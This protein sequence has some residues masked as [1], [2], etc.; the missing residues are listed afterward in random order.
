MHT[1]C[2]FKETEAKPLKPWDSTSSLEAFVGA[3]T[4]VWTHL[5]STSRKDIYAAIAGFYEGEELMARVG[6]RV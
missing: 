6:L 4:P 5:A 3:L 1:T 2:T